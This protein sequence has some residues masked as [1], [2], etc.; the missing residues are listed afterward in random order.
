[1]H[2]FDERRNRLLVHYR[3]RAAE[4]RSLAD[5]FIDPAR[6]TL[7]DIAAMYE[8]LAESECPGAQV[9]DLRVGRRVGLRDL[10]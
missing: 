5:N 9:V 3:K 6:K 1:M 8:K 2:A 4:L 10:P 7:L